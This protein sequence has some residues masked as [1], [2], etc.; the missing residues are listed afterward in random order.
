MHKTQ[1]ALYQHTHSITF[2]GSII[3]TQKDEPT[4]RAVSC[5][6]V[7]CQLQWLKRSDRRLN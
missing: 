1:V 3:Q 5:S 6:L 2:V 7:S 4:C